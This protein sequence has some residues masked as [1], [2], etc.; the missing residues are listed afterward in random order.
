MTTLPNPMSGR[1]VEEWVGKTPD[2]AVPDRVRDRV[3]QR[4]DRRC[5]S[6]GRKIDAG[7]PWT[8]EHMIA[9]ANGGENRESNLDV[10]CSWCL[11]V[12]N[13]AD[14]AQ[15]SKVYKIRA[16]HTGAKKKTG[17]GFPDRAGWYY[18]WNRRQYV[19]ITDEEDHLAQK[20]VENHK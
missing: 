5:H 15:K 10:T 7:E 13:A 6:C 3:F 12:K 2:T 14:V 1:A 9:L 19:R 16:K 4:K 17:R 11:P 20:A 18:D 8:C